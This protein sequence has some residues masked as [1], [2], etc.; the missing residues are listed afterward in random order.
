MAVGDTYFDGA[1]GGCG[2]ARF[3]TSAVAK[4]WPGWMHPLGVPNSSRIDKMLY[5]K[6]YSDRYVDIVPGY[7]TRLAA[8]FVT[9][10]TT[11]VSPNN[12]GAQT[13]VVSNPDNVIVTGTGGILVPQLFTKAQLLQ[14]GSY[15]FQANVND[16]FWEVQT[17]TP[18]TKYRIEVYHRAGYRGSLPT[19][20]PN[21]STTLSRRIIWDEEFTSDELDEVLR[22]WLDGTTDGYQLHVNNQTDALA[23]VYASGGN[24]WSAAGHSCRWIVDRA[25]ETAPGLSFFSPQQTEAGGLGGNRGYGVLRKATYYAPG[26]HSLRSCENTDPAFVENALPLIT[27]PNGAAI[28]QFGGS[29]WNYSDRNAQGTQPNHG[30][31]FLCGNIEIAC[32]ESYSLEAPLNNNVS[33][34]IRQDQVC[35]P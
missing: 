11:D 16:N 3:T 24:T 10:V 25:S 33:V 7:N 34:E 22:G 35:P 1:L 14:P 18:G 4:A 26:M 13:T 19:I 6:S 27:E 2:C 17:F 5:F 28:S 30:N 23:S 21:Y 12:F 15:Y 8:D 20:G 32:G 29:F 31:E 9:M